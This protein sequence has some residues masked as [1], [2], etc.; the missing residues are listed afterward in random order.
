MGVARV[1]NPCLHRLETGATQSYNRSG[2]LDHGLPVARA[3]RHRELAG[4]DRRVYEAGILD[5]RCAFAA[6][7]AV[8][9][10]RVSRTDARGQCRD[11]K[12]QWAT[13]LLRAD[14]SRQLP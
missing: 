1:S 9:N 6:G 8:T 10:Y 13:V 14:L 12:A 5:A 4:G 2:A 11:T 7:R 3:A